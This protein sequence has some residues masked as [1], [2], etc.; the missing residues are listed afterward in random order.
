[1]LKYCNT[2]KGNMNLQDFKEQYG[3]KLAALLKHEN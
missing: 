3:E 2:I 1:M